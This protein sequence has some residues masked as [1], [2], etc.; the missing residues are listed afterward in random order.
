M[1]EMLTAWMLM[2][3]DL[4]SNPALLCPVCPTLV[5]SDEFLANSDNSEPQG[6]HLCSGDDYTS[7]LWLFGGSS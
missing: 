6:L 7:L 5:N 2:S 4:T 3:D 1:A